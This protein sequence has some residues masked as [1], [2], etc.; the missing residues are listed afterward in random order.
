MAF[1]RNPRFEGCLEES[2]VPRSYAGRLTDV[3]SDSTL[4][5]FLA[6]I[7]RGHV[8]AALPEDASLRAERKR[9]RKRN[10][11]ETSAIFGIL[12]GSGNKK[13]EDRSEGHFVQSIKIEEVASRAR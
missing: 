4:S 8:S 9:S 1:D 11:S 6:V 12:R 5:P 2:H 3:R 13:G 10:S 7:L